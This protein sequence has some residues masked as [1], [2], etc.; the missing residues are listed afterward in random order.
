VVRKKPSPI[1]IAEEDETLVLSDARTKANLLFTSF[2]NSE[3]VRVFFVSTPDDEHPRK[4]NNG[5][6]KVYKNSLRFITPPYV[7]I[8]DNYPE[9]FSF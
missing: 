6:K 8:K 2:T 1:E 5:N 4:H 7:Y 3:I 9:Y